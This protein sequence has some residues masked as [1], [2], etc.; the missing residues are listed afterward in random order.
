[1]RQSIDAQTIGQRHVG[2]VE[3]NRL[4]VVAAMRPRLGRRTQVMH[5]PKGVLREP[6][7]V[8]DQSLHPPVFTPLDALPT[9]IT[10]PLLE[11]FQRHG[12]PPNVW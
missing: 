2:H 3:L 8:S 12:A 1:M 11:R 7:V 4:P 5:N 10:N 9:G 6:V